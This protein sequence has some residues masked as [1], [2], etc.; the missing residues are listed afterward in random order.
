VSAA[1][2]IA[3]H[4]P[5][6]P[7]AE[8]WEL[9]LRERERALLRDARDE[10]AFFAAPAPQLLV[11]AVG[12]KLSFNVLTPTNSFQ[13][14]N[15]TAKKVSA[16]AVIYLD[17]EAPA[18]GFTDADLQQ[19][20][21]LF[22]APIHPTVTGVFGQPSDI[23]NNQRITILLTPRVNALTPRGSASFAAGYFY[24]CDLLARSRCSGS[25]LGEIFYS[26]VP[27]P[28]AQ[29]SDRRTTSAVMSIVPPVL[30]H[31]FQHMIHFSRRNLSIDALWLAE[32]L[33]HTAEEIV[34]DAL[35]AQGASLSLVS[36]FKSQN[37][38]RAQRYLLAPGGISLLAE[39]SP[40]SLELR[41]AAWLLL[42]YLRGHYGG[43]A[44]LGALTGS[45]LTGPANISQQTGK[46]WDALMRDFGVAV[47]ADGAPQLSAPVD[48]LHTFR[49]FDPRAV[50]GPGGNYPL[51]PLQFAWS[52]FFATGSI[53]ASS[54]THFLLSAPAGGGTNLNFVLSGP[55]GAATGASTALTI[56]RVR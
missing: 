25:N 34:G 23:D 37:Y 19:L 20:A 49:D 5:S 51:V 17:D 52:D 36:Q 56:L 2:I 27:D 48:V 50:I 28:N 8:S 12:D 45:A 38:N 24:G 46:S 55:Y 32:G 3:A 41:G 47:W 4:A 13:K 14:V 43:S 7:F 35:Q 39:S 16:R 30:A 22:D 53:G 29:W 6:T 42:K 9:S 33:A 18:N 10:G 54:Q 1:A 40:G 26:L 31:E 15:A 11:P 44:L 21:D